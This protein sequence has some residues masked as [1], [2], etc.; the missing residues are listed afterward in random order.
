MIARYLTHLK[1]IDRAKGTIESYKFGLK[2]FADWFV[3]STQAESF[4]PARV[5]PLDVRE[6]RRELQAKRQKPGS[7]NQKT[8]L[9]TAFF[10]WCVA[11]K[12]AASNPARG[13]K[14]MK[15]A[16]AAPKWLT[17]PQ[18]FALLRT[19]EERVQLA[20]IKRHEAGR[21]LARRNA[22]M[23]ALMLHA[24]LRVAEVC[25]I[26]PDDI[27]LLPRSGRVIVRHGK[28]DK[29]REVPL[30][31]DARKAITRWQ[32]I[33]PAPTGGLFDRNGKR[34]HPRTI[35]QHLAELGR[36]AR[37]ETKVTPHM[38]R[39]TFGKNLVDAGIGLE[40]VALLLGHSDVNTTAIY[41]MP[42]ASDLQ[43]AV[44]KI[45]WSD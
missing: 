24:G 4:D 40:R 2:Q 13:I 11:E 37:I 10:D 44:D 38:L 15:Q 26:Q 33:C 23:I 32:E 43:T 17:R 22:A 19:V 7:I 25:A 14:R 30:N 27:Q 29:Y 28:G 45:A 8:A 34:L 41:T 12:V 31:I 6:W 35:Q 5:T 3:K 9:L 42:G 20:D 1:E 36:L 16:A 39:H 18:A 21:W